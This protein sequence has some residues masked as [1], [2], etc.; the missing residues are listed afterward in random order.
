MRYI[1]ELDENRKSMHRTESEEQDAD[2][3]QCG[4]GRTDRAN[5]K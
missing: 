3:D 2:K 1:G 4:D 5:S